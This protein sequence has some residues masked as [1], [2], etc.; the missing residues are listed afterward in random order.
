MPRDEL[1]RRNGLRLVAAADERG[2]V[3]VARDDVV[4]IGGDGA[5]GEFVVIAVGGD[6]AEEEGR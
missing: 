2:E 3:L 1:F 5:V 6:G 4:R